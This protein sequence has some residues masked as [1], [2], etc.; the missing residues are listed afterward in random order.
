MTRTAYRTTPSTSLRCRGNISTEV[1]SSNDKR[2]HRFSFAGYCD[3]ELVSSHLLDIRQAEMQLIITFS[4]TELSPSWGAANCSAT[5]KLRSILWNPKIQYR[6]HNSPP[7]IP[8]L[9]HTN[10]IHTILFHLSKIH[11]NIVQPPTSWSSQ[12]SLSFRLPH[13]YP[14]CIPLHLHSCYM[15]RLP[16]PSWLDHCNYTP[17]RINCNNLKF[18]ATTR[19]LTS[20]QW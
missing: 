12:W 11:F 8:I 3:T 7:L 14:I 13:Q 17:R 18:A 2:I 10:L 5:Q 1:S 4:L 9:S 20:E 16:H 6:V 19:M 15:P